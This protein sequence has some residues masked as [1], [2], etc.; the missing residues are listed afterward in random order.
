MQTPSWHVELGSLQ[1]VYVLGVPIVD[2]VVD[3]LGCGPS[4]LSH[5]NSSLRLMIC[6]SSGT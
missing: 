4:P 6:H 3:G 1:S 5:A 2:A